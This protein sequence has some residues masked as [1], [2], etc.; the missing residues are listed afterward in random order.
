MKPALVA[1]SLLAAAMVV[2]A[3]NGPANGPRVCI[4][5]PASGRQFPIHVDP[6][7]TVKQVK[8][9]I[10]LLASSKIA[11]SEL[12]LEFRGETLDDHK[13][14]Q[15]YNIGGHSEL[16][17]IYAGDFDRVELWAIE[18][19]GNEEPNATV[20]L[21][22]PDTVQFGVDVSLDDTV[23]DLKRKIAIQEEIPLS[24]QILG[25]GVQLEDH[26]RLRDQNLFD[27]ARVYIQAPINWCKH[28]NHIR[29]IFPVA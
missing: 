6:A 4:K 3:A 25:F 5:N 2:S 7:K 8:E 12:E 15:H 27:G 13:T 16:N 21:T 20:Y 29:P 22:G 14:L 26:K 17:L 19:E 23:G 1:F 11:S 10:A 28:S 18:T 24:G 9:T